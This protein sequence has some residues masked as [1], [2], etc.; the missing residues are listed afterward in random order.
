MSFWAALDGRALSALDKAAA[1]AA[2]LAALL[3]ILI[4]FVRRAREEAY[5]SALFGTSAPEESAR[6][7]ACEHLARAWGEISARRLHADPR[8]AGGAIA[9]AMVSFDKLSPD[10]SAAVWSALVVPVRASLAPASSKDAADGE[11]GLA[12]IRG[13][14]EAAPTGASLEEKV[15]NLVRACAEDAVGRVETSVAEVTVGKPLDARSFAPLVSVLKYFGAEVWADEALLEV[16][17]VS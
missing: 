12:L 5:G 8:I 3:D 15:K 6:N 4:F 7:L 9:K 13:V 14:Q 17:T 1:G 11:S 10:L 2:L 16:S